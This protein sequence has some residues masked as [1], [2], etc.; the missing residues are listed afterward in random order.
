MQKERL[1]RSLAAANAG[2]SIAARIAMIAMTT[3]SSIRVKA[4]GRRRRELQAKPPPRHVTPANGTRFR[5]KSK[6]NN[7]GFYLEKRICAPKPDTNSAFSPKQAQYNHPRIRLCRPFENSTEDEAA[8]A[9]QP[10]PHCRQNEHWQCRNHQK[11]H[12]N[13]SLE[14]QHRGASHRPAPRCPLQS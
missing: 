13:P 1:A 4:K 8:S 12:Q 5:P 9:P 6:Y 3:K 7:M 14:T 2:S 11:Q 10:R